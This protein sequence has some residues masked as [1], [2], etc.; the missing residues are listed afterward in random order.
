MNDEWEK[1]DIDWNENQQEIPKYYE[2]TCPSVIRS[3]TDPT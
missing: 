2:K 1:L 3:T